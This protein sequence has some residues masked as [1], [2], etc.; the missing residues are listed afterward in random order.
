MQKFTSC[1]LLAFCLCF[2][3]QMASAQ[4]VASDIF[5]QGR[6]LEVGQ[7]DNGSLGSSAPAPGVYHPYP[8]GPL[9]M[10][11]DY[12]HDGWVPGTP[13]YFGDYT[14]PVSKYEG[15]GLQVNGPS[16]LNWAFSDS[17]G[18]TGPGSLAGHNV[19]Y[20][21]LGGHLTANWS[22]MAAGGNLAIKTHTVVDTS[23][24]WAVI[25][26]GLYNTS[27]IPIPGI[28]YLRSC[29]PQNDY[30][31]SSNP[32]T[33]NKVSYQDDVLHRVMV[34]ST[35]TVDTNA[36]LGLGTVDSRAKAFVYGSWPISGSVTDLAT[37]WAGTALISPQ[38]SVGVADNGDKAI[39]LVYNLGTLPAGDSFSLS[40]SYIFNGVSGIDSAFRH[41]VTT[42]VSSIDAVSDI[43][44]FP[45]PA[46]SWL[47][48][49]STGT[50]KTLAIGN[51]IGQTII[52]H[53]FDSDKVLL[54][55]ADLEPGVYFIRVN[56]NEVRKFV[57]G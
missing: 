55:I 24:S 32:A 10:V 9:A 28:C 57:K 31:H 29:N 30:T 14:L 44:I 22:G 52:T 45:N 53:T 38:Y 21:N 37:V 47:N 16:G 1:F 19:S 50:I 4:M 20:S 43:H 56:G 36:Y 42:S 13:G 18:I 5:L 8:G 7:S 39:G 6:Y 49:T 51:I 12:G 54:N 11:Y 35:G 26:V 41:S 48:I 3:C 2:S 27:A 46:D 17:T 25:T 23:A 40:Y 34:S 15:W 33:N